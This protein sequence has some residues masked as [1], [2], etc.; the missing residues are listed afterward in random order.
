[1]SYLTAA[2]NRKLLERL[3]IVNENV[4]ESEFVTKSNQDVKARGVQR[5][6]ECFLLEFFAENGSTHLFS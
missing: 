4:H 6:A 3:D 1:M 2:T 5:N